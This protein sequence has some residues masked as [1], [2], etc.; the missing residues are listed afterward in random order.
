MTQTLAANAGQ[1][2]KNQHRQQ[3]PRGAAVVCLCK[4]DIAQS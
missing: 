3:A 2:R 1:G 4:E